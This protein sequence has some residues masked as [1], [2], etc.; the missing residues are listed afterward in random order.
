MKPPARVVIAVLLLTVGGI[1]P[2][3][4]QTQTPPAFRS[5]TDAVTVN[6]S[7]R[8]GNQPVD[9]L[10][11]SDFLLTDNGAPQTVASVSMADVPVDVTF[12]YGVGIQ[13]SGNVQPVRAD[14]G[15]MAD[16]LRPTDR[17]RVLEYGTRVTEVFPLQS[18]NGQSVAAQLEKFRVSSASVTGGFTA[19]YDGIMAALILPS[20][21]ERRQ[22]VVAF[23]EFF[24]MISVIS[25]E[26]F[27]AVARR[28]EAVL[29]VQ[30]LPLSP[31][32]TMRQT[33]GTFPFYLNGISQGN[34]DQD[35]ITKAAEATGGAEYGLRILRKSMP[36]FFRNVLA[37]YRRS[38]LLQY[39]IAGIP[40]EGWHEIVVK[41]NRPGRYEIRARKGYFVDTVSTTTRN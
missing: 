29:H 34:R 14:I 25:P 13:A 2:L 30:L 32:M 31:N 28:S 16:L 36:D 3:S 33:R 8:R 38:Y 5:R 21:P 41:L 27:Q 23:Y 17:L 40:L 6:V 19:L 24:D 4:T 39:T 20:V 37:D 15:K 18:A 26:R 1:V 35:E 12:L 22:L 11:A 9:E 10:V 7:V